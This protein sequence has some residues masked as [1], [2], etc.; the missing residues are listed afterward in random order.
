MFKLS[1]FWFIVTQPVQFV[2]PKKQ[3]SSL[4]GPK[5]NVFLFL[6]KTLKYT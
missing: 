2:A 4:D 1:I 3:I 6:K 5:N